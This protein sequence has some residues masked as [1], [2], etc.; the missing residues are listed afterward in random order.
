MVEKQE[1]I[2]RFES[3]LITLINQR[4]IQLKHYLS[5]DAFAFMTLSV[6]YW[7]G[8][9]YWNLWDKDEIEFVE[10]EDFNSSE[11]IALC[12]FHEGNANVSQLSDLLLSI[13]D[14][15]GKEGDEVLS[16][17]EFTHDALTEALNSSK[18]KELL[19][20]VLKSNASFSEDDFNQMVIATT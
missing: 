20:E 8:D 5:Q 7:N 16:L 13:G 18:V 3:V 1:L 4:S 17:I 19:V 12:D 2:G 6:E 11:F 14:V 9:M 15:I 10:Y